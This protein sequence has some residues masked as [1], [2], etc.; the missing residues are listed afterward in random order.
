[1]TTHT[2][3]TKKARPKP[4]ETGKRRDHRQPAPP[5]PML[6]RGPYPARKGSGARRPEK[7]VTQEDQLWL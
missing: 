1:M 7:T 4:E 6:N 2:A 5:G 3:A